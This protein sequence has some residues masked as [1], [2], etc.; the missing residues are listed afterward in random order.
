MRSSHFCA[1]NYRQSSV[2]MKQKNVKI[3]TRSVNMS[4]E[5]ITSMA[6]NVNSV[7]AVLFDECLE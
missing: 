6:P 1:N 4:L 3:G 5:T 7:R 2:I